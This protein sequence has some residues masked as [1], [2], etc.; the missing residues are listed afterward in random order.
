MLGPIDVPADVTF[1]DLGG[2]SLLAARVRGRLEQQLARSISMA[3]LFHY[4]TV[5]TLAAHLER[6]HQAPVDDAPAV[7]RRVERRRVRSAG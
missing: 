5:R 3:D 7:V 1:F 6:Q 4:P 2:H